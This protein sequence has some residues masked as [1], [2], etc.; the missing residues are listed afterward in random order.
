MSRPDGPILVIGVGN[1]LLRDE[2]VGVRVAREIHRLAAEGQL[3]IPEGTRVVDGGTLGLDLLPLIEDA[4]A[5]LMIDA[6]D[7][8]STP[9]TVRVIAGNELHVALAGHVSPHQVG[10]GD[11]LAAARL[12][13]T[14][15]DAVA[16]VAIQPADI[17]VDLALSPDVEA[18]VPEAVL[19]AADQLHVLAG[20]V[21]TGP[22]VDR[23]VATAALG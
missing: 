2:G 10:I 4:R 3:E 13:A 19:V 7:L 1:V 21:G 11:L 20:A 17:S 22:V 15:P 23:S 14:L 9:G 5:L 18:A 8:R 12:M 16:L 6:V